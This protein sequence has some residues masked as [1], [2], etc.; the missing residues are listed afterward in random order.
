MKKILLVAV[1]SRGDVQPLIVLGK[2]LKAVGYEVALLAGKNFEAW[3]TSHGLSFFPIKIDVEDMLNTEYGKAW[4]ENGTKSPL[5]EGRAMRAMLDAHGQSM[6]DDL[7]EFCPQADVLMSNLPT[8]GIVEAIA[9]KYHKPHIRIMF[10]PLTPT[11]DPRITMIPAIPRASSVLN[12]LACYAGIYFIHWVSQKSTN[13][14]RQ[15]LGLN[16]WGWRDYLKAWNRVVAL[17]GISPLVMPPDPEWGDRVLITGYWFDNSGSSWQPPTP[18]QDFLARGD[19]P[20]YVGFGSMPNSDPHKTTQIILEALARTQQRGVIYSGWSNLS[21]E[22]VPETVFLLDKTGAPH[23]WLFPRMKAVIH[24]GGAGTTASA[25]RAGVPS[26]IVA[27]L[28]DQPYWGRRVQELGA[29]AKPI[30]RTQLNARRLTWAIQ[31]MI[32][33][34]TMHATAQRISQRLNA[35][36]GVENAVQAIQ[37]LLGDF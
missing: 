2:A 13:E 19:A 24:H 11:N 4:A 37:Q 26:T 23:D 3:V 14:T 30:K 18:L 15:R 32:E 10:S 9:E 20:I 28:G 16:V 29:G 5:H 33:S 12:R 27:H 36:T 7:L 25:L 31:A 6:A 34:E 1:G 22:A 21:A 8:F 17:T 35:E